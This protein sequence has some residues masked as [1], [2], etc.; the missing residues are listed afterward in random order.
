MEETV[1]GTNTK[2]CMNLI[3]QLY[4]CGITNSNDK[5]GPQLV[6]C[7]KE[8]L[9]HLDHVTDTS[10]LLCMLAAECNTD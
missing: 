3:D 9:T 1:G 5:H 2:Y 6:R 7:K 8:C 4:K 10:G